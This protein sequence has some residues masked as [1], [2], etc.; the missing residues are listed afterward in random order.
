MSEWIT[1]DEYPRRECF[2]ARGKRIDRVRAFKVE[3]GGI[4]VRI[5][6]TVD[7]NKLCVCGSDGDSIETVE[8]EAF[9]KLGTV[10]P[11]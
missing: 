5:L 9:V 6:A 10:K 1:W 8:F 7:G 3:D 2:D 4:R 11:A